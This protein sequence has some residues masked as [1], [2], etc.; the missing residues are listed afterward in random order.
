[1]D[2]KIVKHT[3]LNIQHRIIGQLPASKLLQELFDL[4]QLAI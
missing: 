1:M 3:I 2:D 4:T